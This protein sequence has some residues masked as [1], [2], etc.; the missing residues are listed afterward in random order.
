MPAIKTISD[1]VPP[2]RIL[3]VEDSDINQKI[4]RLM[5]EKQGFQVAVASDGRQAVMACEH[6][7]YDLILMDIQMPVMDGYT[8]ARSIRE[9]ESAGQWIPII[10]MTG[11][12]VESIRDRCL[13][14]G[15]NDCIG[16]PLQREQL[17]SVVK[18]WTAAEP[19]WASHATSRQMS[20]PKP[21]TAEAPLDLSRAIR[22]F[23]GHTDALF[24]LLNGFVDKVRE[25]IITIDQAAAGN[26]YKTISTQAHC[27]KGA[28]AN[29]TANPLAQ[30]AAELEQSAESCAPGQ[31]TE[32]V[33]KL[34][35]QLEQLE[36]FVRRNCNSASVEKCNENFNC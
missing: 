3:L 24:D 29:L 13:E 14:Y 35:V 2:V 22:E 4:V 7:R 9:L 32:L 12:G 33:E 27:I 25:Q 36:R 26:N 23:M 15:M 11:H 30:T 1:P 6:D 34:K 17:L 10:A 20:G 16:K 5:L 31:C 28:A 8:A 18:K 21:P 19:N